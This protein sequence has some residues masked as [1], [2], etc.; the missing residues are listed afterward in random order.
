MLQLQTYFTESINELGFKFWTYIQ[1][2]NDHLQSQVREIVSNY[3][4]YWVEHY[5]NEDYQSVDP[6]I[7]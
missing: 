1:L 3:P 7:N 6:V 5:S 4:N 2:N